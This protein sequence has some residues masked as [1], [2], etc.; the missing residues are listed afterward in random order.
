VKERHI[1]KGREIEEKATED[2][3]NVEIKRRRNSS[4]V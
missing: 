1:R 2:V 4:F 3:G